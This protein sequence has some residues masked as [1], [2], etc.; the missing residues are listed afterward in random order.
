LC[1]V[2]CDARRALLAD[3]FP[4]GIA[5]L[6][7]YCFSA[8]LCGGRYCIGANEGNVPGDGLDFSTVDFPWCLCDRFP[9]VTEC[10]L[11]KRAQVARRNLPGIREPFTL[12][13]NYLV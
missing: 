11:G 7:A 1:R 3:G 13:Y 10:I 5:R 4:I 2:R 6:A 8:R 12:A 9:N